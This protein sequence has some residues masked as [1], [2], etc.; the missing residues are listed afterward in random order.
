M[1]GPPGEPEPEPGRVR[2]VEAVSVWRGRKTKKWQCDWPTGCQEGVPGRG[3]EGKGQGEVQKE[4]AWKL[5]SQELGEEGAGTP[6]EQQ[7]QSTE[8]SP[9][10]GKG[11]CEK[12]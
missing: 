5:G 3:E 4:V 1:P 7:V 12:S 10:R 11:K 2:D 9:R 8:P 6:T